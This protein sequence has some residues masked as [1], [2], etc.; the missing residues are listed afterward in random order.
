MNRKT[1]AKLPT[2]VATKKHWPDTAVAL[3]SGIVTDIGNA[4][5]ASNSTQR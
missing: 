4:I 3:A 2:N 1:S 5:N